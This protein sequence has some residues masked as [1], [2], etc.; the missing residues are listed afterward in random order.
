MLNLRLNLDKLLTVVCRIGSRLAVLLHDIKE[1]GINLTTESRFLRTK[2]AKVP[3]AVYNNINDLLSSDL[4][5][6][7]GS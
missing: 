7:D 4:S 1:R 5:G 3:K 6:S 2:Y